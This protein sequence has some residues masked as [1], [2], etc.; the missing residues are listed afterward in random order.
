MKDVVI[1]AIESSCDETACAIV[2]N[3]HEILSSKVASQIDVHTKYGGVV[4]EVASRIH[5]ENISIVI[6]EALEESSLTMDDIDAIAVTVGPGLIGSLHIG[7]LAAKTLAL[8]YHKPLV[9]VQHITGHIYANAFVDELKFPLLALVVSGGHTELVIMKEDYSFE[10][11]GT[12]QDDAIGE[13]YDKVGRVLELPYPGG[14]KIDKLAKEGKPVYQL[15]RVHTDNPLNFSFS[16]LKSAV[17]QSIKRCER[18]GEELNVA[19]MCT[20]FQEAAL[21]HLWSRVEEALANYDVKQLVLAGG[22]AANSRLREICIERM[23]KHPDVSYII[24]PLAYCT[25]NAAMIGASGY[26]AYLK[27]ITADLDVEADASLELV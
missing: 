13:A 10:E 17:M 16:G 22:V 12:T 23:K 5:V 19:D 20:S 4:P 9:P 18:N 7:V 24:P 25:D 8:T 1:L 6:K 27:G 3:G 21:N 15:P 2:R 26:R 11:I 14:P